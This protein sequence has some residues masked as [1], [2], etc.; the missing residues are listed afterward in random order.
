MRQKK[1]SI[2]YSHAESELQHNFVPPVYNYRSLHANKKV[3]VEAALANDYIPTVAYQALR[4][5]SWLLCSIL[6]FNALGM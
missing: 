5:Y 2:D 6:T 4:I 1:R 3:I